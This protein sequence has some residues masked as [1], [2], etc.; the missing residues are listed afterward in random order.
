MRLLRSPEGETA[1]WMLKREFA[2]MREGRGNLVQL[3]GQMTIAYHGR[4]SSDLDAG[5]RL[6]LFKP[7]GT[8]LVHTATK[9]KPVN[10]QPPGSEFSAGLEGERL[11][12]LSRRTDPDETVTM[13]VERVDLLASFAL[14]D[15]S[16]LVLRGTEEQIHAVLAAHPD[17]LEPGL[18]I[19]GR[20]REFRRGPMDLY[21]EDNRGRRVVVE[22]KRVPA[23]IGDATQL[24]RYVEHERKARAVAV[25]G[26]LA[27]PSCSDA[28]RRLL[29]DHGLEFAALDWAKM[30][31]HVQAPI[32]KAQTNLTRFEGDG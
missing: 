9:I 29:V 31:P 7:D 32:P 12:V 18:R 5:E 28:G 11:V 3:V 20:E 24:W 13:D 22:V 15:G 26:I 21:G 2:A 8:L 19:L 16:E 23:G 6:V 30:L 4:A 10:W 17:L 25:R 27:A 1:L 14:N